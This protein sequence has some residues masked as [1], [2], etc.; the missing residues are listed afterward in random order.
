MDTVRDGLKQDK[1]EKDTFDR[2]ICAECN[3]AL[4][5]RNDPEELGSVRFCEDCGAEWLEMR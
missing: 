2:L 3:R 5:I 4:S 1:L